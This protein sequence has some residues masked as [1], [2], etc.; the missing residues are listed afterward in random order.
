[1]DYYLVELN[2][3]RD[4]IAIATWTNLGLCG[5]YSHTVASIRRKRFRPADRFGATIAPPARRP[6]RRRCAEATHAVAMPTTATA[7]CVRPFWTLASIRT[8][9]STKVTSVCLCV[10]AL[11]CAPKVCAC[12][13]A[14]V[15]LPPWFSLAKPKPYFKDGR[16]SHYHLIGPPTVFGCVCVC[17]RE[18]L[19]LPLATQIIQKLTWVANQISCILFKCFILIF[20]RFRFGFCHYYLVLILNRFIHW[21]VSTFYVERWSSQFLFKSIYTSADCVCVK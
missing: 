14:L 3:W 21:F 20:Q 4:C 11:L 9:F 17:V 2:H 8:R 13:V 12:V 19:C 18:W 6:V 10:F 1:M 16:E 5:T 15:L 7:I